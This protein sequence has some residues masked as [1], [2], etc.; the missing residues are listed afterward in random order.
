MLAIWGYDAP[1]EGFSRAKAAAQR[2][3]LLDSTLAEAHTSLGI[4]SL[5]Y[6][7]DWPAAEREL[8]RA[9]A[10]DRQYAPAHLFQ[11]WHS[12]I[13]G[14]PADALREVQQ[15][16]ELDPL[17]VILNARWAT[18]LYYAHRYDEAIAQL[19]KTL[20]LDST[21][22]LVHAELA[23]AYLQAN[24]CGEA[25]AAARLIP[26]SLPNP[27][28]AVRGYA[29]A[30]CGN[31]A[32]AMRVLGELKTQVRRG[33]VIPAKVALSYAALGDADSTF[34]WLERG[35][36]GRDAYMTFLKVE[37]LYDTVRNDP[38]FAR[39]VRRVGLEP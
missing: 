22:A 1:R 31:R 3:L 37:P 30:R 39:L 4:I 29:Y 14:S 8:T 12:L 20:E 21:N 18:I 6:D 17:S 23:R 34:A 13:V 16:I 15:A 28:G 10:L 33:Y 7:W 24:R 5:Y 11:A 26:V 2:A 36:E 32:E 25:I 35:Y 19:R 38:R 27:E 9:I